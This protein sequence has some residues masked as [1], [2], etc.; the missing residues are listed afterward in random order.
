MQPNSSQ[1][2]Q[3]AEVLPVQSPEGI[4]AMP[5][6]APAQPAAAER[7]AGGASEPAAAPVAVPIVDPVATPT[8]VDDT[9][10]ISTPTKAAD[11]QLIEK[12]WV[13]QAEKIID[14]YGDDPR[15]EEAAEQALSTDYLKKRFN[16]RIDDT[17]H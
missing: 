15:R 8:T 2:E 10:Q 9:A 6:V 1:P 5:E 17:V 4:T 7:V 11:D 16:Y 3:S 13:D 12:E 14:K